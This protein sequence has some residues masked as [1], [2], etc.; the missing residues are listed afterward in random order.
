[1]IKVIFWDVD[2]VLVNL[3]KT[4]FKFIT[5]CDKFKKYFNNI[6]YN[7]LP[8]VLPINK[9]YG[10]LE[11]STHPTLGKE[12][13][14]EFC[15]SE[16]YYFD[17]EFY[18]DTEKVLKKL[19]DLGYIQITMSAGFNIEKKTKLLDNLFRD[20]P[21]IK[22]ITVEH[23]KSGMSQGNTKEKKNVRSFKRFEYK[24]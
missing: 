6:T 23:D 14:Y 22:K 9:E 24:T 13:D 20:L 1:M 10:A 4:Y 21:F 7:D 17:R 18:P 5:T 11:L 8:K 2:G 19:N 15:K 3:N 12:L 16:D